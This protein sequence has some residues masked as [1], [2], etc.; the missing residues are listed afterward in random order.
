[1][2]ARQLYLDELLGRMV[3]AANNRPVGRLEEFHAEQNGDYFDIVEF[4]IGSAGLLD[5]LNVAVKS[6]FGK[7]GGG[8]VARWD[9]L[10]VS[11]PEHPRLTCA[12]EELQDLEV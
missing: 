5:R 8:K 6:L 3:I 2:K 4:V 1:M 12:I 11:D 7:A 9:Q 10:D